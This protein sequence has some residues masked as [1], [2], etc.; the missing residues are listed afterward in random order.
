MRVC[1][2]LIGLIFFLALGSAGAADSASQRLSQLETQLGGRLGV[3]ALDTGSGRKIT[4]RADERFPMCSTFKV[5]AVSAVLHRIDQQQDQL[6]RF[7]PYSKA[8]L[9]EYAPVTTAHVDKG[10]MTLGALCA[11]ALQ[12][13]DNT[14]AN[15]L[16]KSIQGPKG[17]TDYV[18]SL[19]DN[20]TR[21]DRFEPDL[22]SATEGD[23]RDTTTPAAMLEDLRRLLLDDALSPKSRALLNAW[24]LGN[25]TGAEL[26]RAGVPHD[27]QVG[28]KTGR[29][30][31][32]AT[33][34]IAILHPPRK[35]PILL[36]VYSVGSAASPASRNAAIAAAAR[37]VT[38][39]FGQ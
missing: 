2:R 9:L 17:L 29:G 15:L 7:V 25:K 16:L 14:A 19:G 38:K 21:L 33:N 8:D 12:E 18:R 26:I 4:L 20:K 27:W 10:G 13:S 31:H 6:S 23:E 24:L 11:A 34:D 36:A 22:N 3:A 5:L 39:T 37:I 35:A 1:S 32:G 30:A 28:D